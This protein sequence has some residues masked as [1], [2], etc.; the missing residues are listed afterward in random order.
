MDTALASLVQ[1]RPRCQVRTGG[2]SRGK[3]RRRQTAFPVPD[4]PYKAQSITFQN[5]SRTLWGF[6]VKRFYKNIADRNLMVGNP[7]FYTLHASPLMQAFQSLIFV[8]LHIY[9][10]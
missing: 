7:G 1:Y 10:S 8:Y 2:K 4:H 6:A 5:L 9:P 3:S